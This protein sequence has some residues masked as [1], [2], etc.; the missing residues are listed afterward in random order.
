MRWVW[1]VAALLCFLL[2]AALQA[3]AQQGVWVPG[4]YRNIQQVPCGTRTA[5]LQLN[6]NGSCVLSVRCG[7]AAE[8]RYTGTWRQWTGDRVDVRV[9]RGG[10]SYEFSFRGDGRSLA[11]LS[12]DRNA[13]GAA[14]LEFRRFGAQ[15]EQPDPAL[16]TYR[17]DV[18]AGEESFRLTLVLAP[19]GNA[20]LEVRYLRRGGLPLR[21]S[22]TWRRESTGRYRLELR[23]MLERQNFVFRLSGGELTA[24]EWDRNRWG[25]NPPRLRRAS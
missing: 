16:G 12:W 9:S 18:R 13:W 5:D 22:G 23:R 11:T 6:P 17:G 10:V 25:S 3:S 15:P 7:S 24:V 14:A 21:Y 4:T 2:T 8:V 19:G 1:S 20:E